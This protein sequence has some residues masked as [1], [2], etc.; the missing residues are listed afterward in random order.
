[1][2]S[3]DPIGEAFEPA[4]VAPRGFKPAAAP[5]RSPNTDAGRGPVGPAGT[6]PTG[7]AGRRPATGARTADPRE[8]GVTE[9]DK[10]LREL[11]GG[12]AQAL[13]EVEAGR[14]PRRQLRPVVSVELGERLAPLGAREGSGPGRVVRVCGS[15]ATRDRYEAVA[16]VVRGERYG[17]LAVSLARR[18]GRWLVVEAARPEDR[19]SAPPAPQDPARPH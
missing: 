10:T 11:V 3:P 18:R 2:A 5:S 19:H 13:L 1:M 12:F 6:S 8:R 9:I 17:A 16:V 7:R 14:R 15:R 4:G